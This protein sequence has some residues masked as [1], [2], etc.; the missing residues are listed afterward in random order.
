MEVPFGRFPRHHGWT[1]PGKLASF[2]PGGVRGSISSGCW[3]RVASQERGGDEGEGGGCATVLSQAPRRSPLVAA[4]PSGDDRH[5]S[6]V[7]LSAGA[8]L[9]CQTMSV[10]MDPAAALDLV[11]DILG[12]REEFAL[13]RADVECPTSDRLKDLC[14]AE[15]VTPAF[16][17]FWNHSVAYQKYSNAV[18]QWESRTTQVDKMR[19]L[20]E[21][22]LN[23]EE[24]DACTLLNL[25]TGR[26]MS[27]HESRHRRIFCATMSL[28]NSR[29]F[30]QHVN[31]QTRGEENVKGSRIIQL[32]QEFTGEPF[33]DSFDKRS[34][35]LGP[36]EKEDRKRSRLEAVLNTEGKCA[37]T[38]KAGPSGV[39]FRRPFCIARS[40]AYGGLLGK[41]TVALFTLLLAE[42]PPGGFE[43]EDGC[44]PGPGARS[45]LQFLKGRS[46]GMCGGST[47]C[48]VLSDE[49][50][51]AVKDYKQLRTR[52][53]TVK[54]RYEACARE[55]TLPEERDFWTRLA[56]RMVLW[57]GCDDLRLQF[58]LCET[59][60]V[61][62]M[63]LANRGRW[64]AGAGPHDAPQPEGDDGDALGDE[65]NDEPAAAAGAPPDALRLLLDALRD[66]E[67]L[68]G[69]PQRRGRTRPDKAEKAVERAAR[70]RAR[71]S[72]G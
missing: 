47:C 71:S 57:R 27:K 52:L 30:C 50:D 19:I 40:R 65:D 4:T 42:E 43:K 60:K 62:G 66:R 59:S 48:G 72:P 33:T 36:S 21:R 45:G 70:K 49:F 9:H 2:D 69:Q 56:N 38:L 39:P 6:R 17:R 20:R 16:R 5:E 22:K 41:N 35:Y 25:D 53:L 28:V 44:V 13:K 1:R 15:G 8:G 63:V 64:R 46:L 34:F 14:S 3:P 68:E 61:A 11:C 10:R 18:G 23:Y 37:L 67:G 32:A 26:R 54:R 51:D 12:C 29:E 58:R 24:N 7:T 55:A 31:E